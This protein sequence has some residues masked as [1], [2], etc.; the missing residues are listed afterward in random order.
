M[1]EY[2]QHWRR[3]VG[4]RVFGITVAA[5]LLQ[6]LGIVIVYLVAGSWTHIKY[7]LNVLRRLRLPKR[8]EFRKDAYVGYSDNDWR[9]ACLV[10]FESL[11]ERRGVR[12][13]LR[14]QEELPGSVR[15]ENIIEHIDESWKV[16]LLVTRDFAQDEW[17]CGFTV[18]Q[19]QRSITDTMPDRVI[20]VFME[21]PARLPPMASLERLLRMVPER[22]VLHVHRDTPPHHPAWDRVAE[23]IIGR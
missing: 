8:D 21:D 11:Q 5:F 13:L 4:P 17:L 2:D 3:C 22:N 12:L 23:A 9:L 14:D 20:V 18:Q 10:L 6:I 16:L 15:A 7:A 1:A 19:A